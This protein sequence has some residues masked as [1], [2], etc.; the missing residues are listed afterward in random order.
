MWHWTGLHHVLGGIP[1]LP[2]C[3]FF[4]ITVFSLPHA[5]SLVSV[6]GAPQHSAPCQSVA[7]SLLVPGR[8]RTSQLFFLFFFFL[9]ALMLLC[10]EWD[11]LPAVHCPSQ[12][13]RSLVL[14]QLILHR[15]CR[16]QRVRQR[17]LTCDR[18][19]RS[20]CV[21]WFQRGFWFCFIL[22]TVPLVLK[23]VNWEQCRQVIYYQVIKF[24]FLFLVTE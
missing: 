23:V 13:F 21:K 18:T 8:C 17:Q 2:V 19:T 1:S 6:Q 5:C 10:Q 4:L 24:P 3:V 16:L 7:E 9:K 11:T 12:V 14:R 20:R 22:E 15:S